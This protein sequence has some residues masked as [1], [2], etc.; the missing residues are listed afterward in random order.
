MARGMRRRPLVTPSPSTN[1]APG[2]LLP[3]WAP[4]HAIY[5]LELAAPIHGHRHR[6]R[7]YQQRERPGASWAWLF[8]PE[9][10]PLGLAA[11]ATQPHADKRARPAD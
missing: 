7:F 11:K 3:R 9:T 8:M 6:R 2:T 4:G 5:V 1:K 10:M